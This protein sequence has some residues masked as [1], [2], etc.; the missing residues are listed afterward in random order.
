MFLCITKSKSKPEFLEL[1]NLYTLYYLLVPFIEVLREEKKKNS[2]S[3][4]KMLS[5]DLHSLVI[6]YPV[7]QFASSLVTKSSTLYNVKHYS[8]DPALMG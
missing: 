6:S 1:N 8:L 5:A 2:I 3:P 7:T 4:P